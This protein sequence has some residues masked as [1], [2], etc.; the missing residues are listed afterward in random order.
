LTAQWDT[1]HSVFGVA[2]HAGGKT[3]Q[4]PQ[5]AAQP[6]QMVRQDRR[7]HAFSLLCVGPRGDQI[8]PDPAI[9]IMKRCRREAGQVPTGGRQ[10]CA[11]FDCRRWTATS[12][13]LSYSNHAG[14]LVRGVEQDRRVPLDDE[15]GIG[16]NSRVGEGDGVAGWI[17]VAAPSPPIG[18]LQLRGTGAAP[19]ALRCVLQPARHSAVD[20]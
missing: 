9:R 7:R 13:N 19:R 5:H 6:G 8:V 20:R 18:L 2:W 12:N 1:W 16:G 14:L 3:G 10:Q 15:E 11:S 17:H 4:N